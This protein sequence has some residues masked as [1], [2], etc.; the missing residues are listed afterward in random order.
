MDHASGG[1]VVAAGEQLN[2]PALAGGHAGHRIL[3]GGQDLHELLVVHRV[4]L[5]GGSHGEQAVHA[6][7]HQPLAHH[8]QGL[9]VHRSILMEGGDNGGRDPIGYKS[10]GL[11][12]F[13]S[14]WRIGAWRRRLILDTTHYRKK[15]R[16]NN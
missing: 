14:P 10:H 2:G 3:H 1:N 5:T 4:K 15:T 6:V 12:S 11:S 16:Q 9:I 13:L 7:F 8:G